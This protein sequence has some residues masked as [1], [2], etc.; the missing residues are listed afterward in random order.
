MPRRAGANDPSSTVIVNHPGHT[1]GET[2]PLHRGDA[3]SAADRD[4]LLRLQRQALQYFVDNQMPNGLTLDRQHNHGPRRAH[5]LC[6]TAATGMGF[7]A[8][9]LA[10]APPYRL[11]A[12]KEAI[13]RVRAGL[14]AVLGGLPHDHGVV[15]HFVDSAT[16]EII[17]ADY[18]STVESAWL[19]VGALWAAA[20]LAD[21]EVE[22]LAARFYQR[23]DWRYW[24]A[25]EENDVA[26]FGLPRCHPVAPSA[27]YALLSHGK[28]RDGHFLHHRWDRLNGETA[29]MYVLA[30]GADEERAVSAACWTALEPY[31]GT[32]AGLRYS[33]ADLGLFVFQYGLDLVDLVQW[34]GPGRA[35]LVQ[36]ARLAAEA[37]QR[38][39]RESATTFA[40]YRRYWGLSAGDG[41]GQP[42]DSDVYRCYAP[43]GPVDGTA[44]ITATLAS[45]AQS[46]GAVLE[47]LYQA[48]RDASFPAHGR[49]G[50]S[51]VNVDRGWIGRDMVG[52]DAGAAVMALDNYL[53]ENRVRNLFHTLPCVE[54][55][56]QRLGFARAASPECRLS[57]EPVRKAS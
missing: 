12:A 24:T 45:V 4:L 8:L 44:H 33:N 23:V 6:S 26:H 43:A 13:A 51:N 52:I 50:F 16:G 49:Y 19:T 55:G 22:A 17:G 40:T 1:T 29:F 46:P 47:N 27:R 57:A 53:H 20:L 10:S 48:A 39:C 15:P 14:L 28:S 56:L 30:G 42:P 7:I 25:A 31:Y 2:E 34:R 18:F 35:D 21:Q 54:R 32:V 38:A 36:D 37:N 9:A 5:G 41:P 11:L 3:L